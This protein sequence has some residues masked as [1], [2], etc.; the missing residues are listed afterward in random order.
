MRTA[1]SKQKPDSAFA[2]LM[3]KED[4]DY[5]T[6]NIDKLTPTDLHKIK[7]P[8]DYRCYVNGNAERKR[9]YMLGCGRSH[10]FK[11]DGRGKWKK[12]DEDNIHMELPFRT[13]LEV[14]FVQELKGEGM[15]Q[16]R[17]MTV[18]ALDALFLYGNDVRKLHYTDRIEKLRRFVKSITKKTRPNLTP[19]IVPFI[20]RLEHIGQIFERL[21]FKRVKGSST[22]RL[23]YFPPDRPDGRCFL[24]SG[25]CILK[26]VKEPWTIALSK[27][28]NRKYFYN[29]KTGMSTFEAPPDS[30]ASARECKLSSYRWDFEIGVKIHDSQTFEPDN[31][32]ISRENMLNHINKLM[33]H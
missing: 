20:Y 5:V 30:V 33:P 16:K 2:D 4:T 31:D 23:C 8:F 17:L 3:A 25:V 14:E 18:H 24:P 12:L 9:W 28:A 22:P 1:P 32:K 13:L 26:T 29:L 27:S 6:Y 19:I 7:S 21:E 10:V 15:G 11:W